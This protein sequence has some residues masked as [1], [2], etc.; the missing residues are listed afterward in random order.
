[1]S[2]TKLKISER[3]GLDLVVADGIRE[4]IMSGDLACGAHLV[5]AEFAREF[6][7]SHGTVR[8]AFKALQGEGLVE[9][10]P[11]RGMFVVT[12]EPDDVLELCSLRDSLESLGAR[13]AAQ[14]ATEAD[15]TRLQKLL[16]DLRSAVRRKDRRACMELDMGFHRFVVDLSG[17]KRLQQMYS[18]LEFQVRL[19]MVLTESFHSN[20]ADMV[21][22][23]EPLVNAIVSGDSEHAAMLSSNHNK[24]D[25]EALADA[26]RK[27]DHRASA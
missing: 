12:L 20:L 1:M 24:A 21:T 26:L 4:K 5:E 7:V 10:R 25:G 18:Q 14:N 9:Y 22:I 8:A 6:E 17:H 3:P 15:R 11:R 19:F 16:Q 27:K 2:T 23:H 13:L